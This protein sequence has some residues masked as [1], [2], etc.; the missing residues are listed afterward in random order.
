MSHYQHHATGFSLSL[1]FHGAILASLLIGQMGMQSSPDEAASLPLSLAMFHSE[2]SARKTATTQTTTTEVVKNNKPQT[3]KAEP[4]QK[5]AATPITPTKK[6]KTPD[7]TAKPEPAN[8]SMQEAT[9]QPITN[10]PADTTAE[11][12]SETNEDEPPSTSQAASLAASPSG[13]ADQATTDHGI[14]K[15]LEAEYM[16]ALRSA[17]EEKKHYPKRARRLK[18]EGDVIINFVINRN[19][20]IK[21]VRIRHSSGTQLLDKAAIDAIKRVGQFKPIPAE[22]P[23]NSWALELPIRYALM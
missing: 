5:T 15:S 16:A 8:E 3:V 22:I 10:R 4:S 2:A 14:I 7:I 13:M 9:S 23:R 19:G 21:N 1:L 17:I 6:N 11:K 12:S 18:R 20:Q